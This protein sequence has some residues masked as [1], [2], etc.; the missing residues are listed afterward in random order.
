MEIITPVNLSAEKIKQIVEKE[1]GCIAWGGAVKLSPAD[2]I[3]IS[4]ERS[5][6]IDSDGQMIASVLSK[7]AAAGA[8][9][10]VIDIPVGPT[11]KIRSHEQALKLQYYFKAAAEAIGLHVEIE[12]TDGSQPVGIGIGPALEAFDIL[13]V[14]RNEEN[15]PS[16]L[17]SRAL[18]L[19]GTLLELSGKFPK[20][21]GYKI[22][23]ELLESGKALNKFMA[24]CAMQGGFKEPTFAKYKYDMISMDEGIVKF[25]DSRKLSRIAKLAGAPK[26]PRAGIQFFSPLGKTIIKGDVL[27]SVYTDSTG[28]LEYAKNYINN[29]SDLITIE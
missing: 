12:I 23:E 28:E 27:F 15:S 1:G 24:I 4:V 29:L 5:L 17:K 13:S 25:I 2:D 19:S 21:E 6:D 26:S 8:T 18:K 22:A 20:G 16:D 3:L 10:V 9:H 7:K 11:A 14:L